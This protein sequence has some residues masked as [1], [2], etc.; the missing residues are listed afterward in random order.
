M[1]TES[2]SEDSSALLHAQCWEDA[3]T[4]LAALE[5]QPGETVVSVGSGGD[6]PLAILL[7]DPI[8]VIGVDPH[9]A[10]IACGEL[11]EIVY[12]K[13]GY[14]EYLELAGS[15]TSIRRRKLLDEPRPIMSHSGQ[16]SRAL[17]PAA[18]AV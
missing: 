15:R 7:A 8:R 9:P 1:V 2:E 14:G 17:I 16:I 4:L 3:D 5:V 12:Q 13:L 11:K 18:L 6:N 10:Q